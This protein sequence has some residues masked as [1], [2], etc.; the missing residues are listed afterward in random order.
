MVKY[1][2]I[3]LVASDIDGTL[4][5]N[6]VREL[7]EEVIEQIHK[8]AAHGVLFVAASGRQMPN[9]ERL[10]EPVKD[11]IAYIAENGALVVYKNQV[12]S[13]TPLPAGLGREILKDIREREGCEILL[14]GERTSYLEPKTKEYE[15]HMK[16]FVKN[17]VTVVD[18]ILD[19]EEDF[20]KISVYEKDGISN[21]TRYFKE[22]WGNHV[23]VVTSGYAWLDMVAAG[24]NKGTAMK[25][26]LQHLQI[27]RSEAVAFG[28]NYN[29]VE[30]FEAVKYSYAMDTA[31]PGIAPRCYGT[32]DRVETMLR[33]WLEP[34]SFI[35]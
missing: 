6:G 35:W 20:L 11:K 9:L 5:Q 34:G 1:K 17:N 14:S 2:M 33:Q 26:L 21:C 19:V 25:T 8:L 23:T 22:R 15:E 10:F 16:F 32:C 28:D 3:K 12:L 18:N 27:D 24:V 4:L 31:Q 30:M 29:D 7:S 13:R